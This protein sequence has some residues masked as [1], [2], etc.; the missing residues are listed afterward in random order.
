MLGSLWRDMSDAEKDP[1]HD[2]AAKDAERYAEEL[3]DY[4]QELEDAD[5][6][7]EAADVAHGTSESDFEN[8]GDDSDD[9]YTTK[10][11][12]D[13]G[14]GGGGGGGGGGKRKR[15]GSSGGG[16]RKSAKDGDSDCAACNGAHKAHTCGRGI[17]ASERSS[18]AS[19]KRSRSSGGGGSKSGGS[20]RKPVAAA[21]ARAPRPKSTSGA[22]AQMTADSDYAE[23]W[24][25]VLCGEGSES[26]NDKNSRGLKSRKTD[27]TELR[28]Q[29]WKHRGILIPGIRQPLM[30]LEGTADTEDT[31]P[32]LLRAMLAELL[33][34]SAPSTA[35]AVALRGA[36]ASV[37]SG[38]SGGEVGSLE[39]GDF[40]SVDTSGGAAVTTPQFP[41]QPALCVF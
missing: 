10:K 27:P 41:P 8:N 5:A 1:F 23:K 40:V 30:A 3:E 9:D 7:A 31:D 26:G 4:E 29:V 39:A 38:G 17:S 6:A 35:P 19:G 2:A 11:K 28:E 20:K 32:E 36:K 34:W 16:K 25:Y 37:N 14:Y 15:R 21:A 24:T 13:T 22:G 33:I 12:G 18:R